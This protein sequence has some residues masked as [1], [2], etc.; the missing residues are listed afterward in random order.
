MT[1]PNIVPTPNATTKAIGTAHHSFLTENAPTLFEID[2][3]AK[4]YG[5]AEDVRVLPVVVAPLEV[6]SHI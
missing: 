2:A 5:R 4:C 3:S 1:R 6:G